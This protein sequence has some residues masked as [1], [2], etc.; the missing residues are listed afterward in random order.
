MLFLKFNKKKMLKCWT[1]VIENIIAFVEFLA[2]HQLQ[3]TRF[4]LYQQD[5]AQLYVKKHIHSELS[6]FVT[7]MC[8]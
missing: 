8:Q 2:A 4:H 7:W 3:I 1:A 5:N 6:E